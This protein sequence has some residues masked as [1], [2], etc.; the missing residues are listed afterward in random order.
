MICEN[1]NSFIFGALRLKFRA[2]A[3]LTFTN[4]CRWDEAKNNDVLP[5][6]ATRRRTLN[7]KKMYKQSFLQ[8]SEVE[9]VDRHP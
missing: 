7:S 3:S 8:F 2:I 5:S 9:Q 1:L 4:L 6:Q